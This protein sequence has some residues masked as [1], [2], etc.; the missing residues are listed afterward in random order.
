MVI[1]MYAVML[2]VEYVCGVCARVCVFEAFAPGVACPCHA[3]TLLLRA[4]DRHSMMPATV[5]Q[6][7]SSVSRRVRG[8][9]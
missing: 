1:M 2:I 5:S 6:S 8:S 9:S 4:I 7:V 3:Y